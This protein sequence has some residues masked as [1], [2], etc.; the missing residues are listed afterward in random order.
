M[1]APLADLPSGRLPLPSAVCRKGGALS[2]SRGRRLPA[3]RAPR[4]R[5]GSTSVSKR[6][7][8][9]DEAR[10]AVVDVSLTDR[11]GRARRP[12]RSFR[13]RQDDPAQTDQ[14]PLRPEQR[15]HLHRWHTFPT[16]RRARPAPSHGLR[17]PA[18]WSVPALHGRGERGRRPWSAGMGQ[19]AYAARVDELLELVG[20]PPDEYRSRYPAQ[21]SGGQQ[22]R[23][24][25]ARAIAAGPGTLLMD[26]PFGALDA[27]TRGRLQE[28]LRELH[29]RLGQTIVFVTHDIDEA[30]LLADRIAVMRE[31]A[32]VQFDT[33]VNVIMRPANSFVAELVGADD[34][35]AGSAW[36]ASPP[37]WLPSSQVTRS[38]RMS[39]PSTSRCGCVPCSA[40][41]WKRGAA[42]DRRRRGRAGRLP[43]SAGDP[44]GEHSPASPGTSRDPRLP[45]QPAGR[46]WELTL[47]HLKL[48]AR[49]SC[50]RSSSP[51]RS[52]SWP[53]ATP[54]SDA[55]A[56]HPGRDLHHPQ[57][58]VPG[59]ADPESGHR[60][61][62]AIVVLA[63]YAQIFLVRNIATGLRGVD[64]ATLEA[65]HGLGMT[66][67]QEFARVRWPLA[68]PVIIAGLRTAR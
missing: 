53:P 10:P 32:V 57:P 5:S 35:C 39:P 46:V 52:A 48:S 24:G 50:W 18:G 63:A 58:G 41:S 36:S 15:R 67:W 21:L 4:P 43:R 22:Q 20:L 37:P 12:H 13:L 19:S 25:I 47:Q 56:R 7:D 61:R 65:A 55:D 60:S 17:H 30:V 27:I 11:A 23:V 68:L 28:E 3:R 9:G 16:A 1:T 54:V 26:E 6:F 38:V 66:R 29:E 51:S 62:P 59:L 8:N 44:G 42:R 49:P 14:P 64:P 40:F 45:D 31:G 34:S 33:P 2:R